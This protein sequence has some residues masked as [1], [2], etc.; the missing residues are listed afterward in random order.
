MVIRTY[1]VPCPILLLRASNAPSVSSYLSATTDV[2]AR[3]SIHKSSAFGFLPIEIPTVVRTCCSSFLLSALDSL[4][5]KTT[6]YRTNP[7]IAPTT[8]RATTMITISTPTP[9]PTQA[10]VASHGHSA[11]ICHSPE[12]LLVVPPVGATIGELVGELVGAPVPQFSPQEL[13]ESA[14]SNFAYAP[15][16]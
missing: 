16:L 9:I 7:T 4:D 12:S 15:A 13:A 2:S 11:I 6:K 3:R 8:T 5:L 1:K 10:T 14:A